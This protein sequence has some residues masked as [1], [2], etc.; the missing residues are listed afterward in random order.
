MHGQKKR[1]KRS[2][3][4]EFE[5]DGAKLFW[6]LI[7]E[8]QLTSDG[9]RGVCISVM[10]AGEHHRELIL[11]YP[12]PGKT[13]GNGSPQLPQRPTVSEKQVEADT[14]RAMVAGWH[15]A[16]RG[17]AFGFEVPPKSS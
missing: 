4:G 1:R 2:L 12:M 8:P 17:K 6:R 16:S 3:Q 13:T 5:I 7:S 15:P 10:P 11:E 9:Y 14:R